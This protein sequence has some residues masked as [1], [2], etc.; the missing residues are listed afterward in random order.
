MDILKIIRLIL[1]FFGKAARKNKEDDFK[2][3]VKKN[4]D[5]PRASFKSK[6]MRGDG[7][8]DERKED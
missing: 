3:D 2:D 1:E 5:D 8:D 4:N 7:S 6:F